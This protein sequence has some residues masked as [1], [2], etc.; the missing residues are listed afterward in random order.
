MKMTRE[1]QKQKTARKLKRSRRGNTR[2]GGREGVKKRENHKRILVRRK[3]EE[4]PTQKEALA[5]R[6]AQ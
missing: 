2:L 6:E 4:K 3:K 5:R 1:D